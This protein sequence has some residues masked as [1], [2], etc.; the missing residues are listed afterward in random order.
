MPR[1]ASRRCA[2]VV[3]TNPGGT[4]SPADAVLPR[5]SPLPP[6][7]AAL[8]SVI[9]LKN[10]MSGMSLHFL[11]FQHATVFEDGPEL[12]PHGFNRHRTEALRGPD[13]RRRDQ[14]R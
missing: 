2:S 1:F 11:L 12:L 9:S 7:R 14:H 4:G 5:L 13:L 10:R 3:T 8:A 6:T